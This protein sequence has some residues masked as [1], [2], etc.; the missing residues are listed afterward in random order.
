MNSVSCYITLYL[1]LSL[2]MHISSLNTYS[3]IQLSWLYHDIPPFLVIFHVLN[4]GG[5]SI[6]RGLNPASLRKNSNRKKDMMVWGPRRIQLG[7]NPLYKPL[8]P[9]DLSVFTKQSKVLLYLSSL[10]ETPVGNHWKWKWRLKG[11]NIWKA[12]R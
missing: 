11:C 1:L 7:I 2:N 10:F 12:F 4:G 8:K 9:S 6:Y 5:L 3:Y